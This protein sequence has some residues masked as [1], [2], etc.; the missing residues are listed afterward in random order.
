MILAHPGPQVT[1]TTRI[2]M[3]DNINRILFVIIAFKDA[4]LAA[5]GFAKS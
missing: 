3:K 1:L 5:L 2:V 4:N